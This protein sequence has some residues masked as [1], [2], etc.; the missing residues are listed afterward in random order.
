M[1]EAAVTDIPNALDRLAATRS[2]VRQILRPEYNDVQGSA[3][4]FPRS[5][6]MRALT[7]RG[8]ISALALVGVAILA[9]R[10][11]IAGRLAR[12]VPLV[13]LLRQLRLG[14]R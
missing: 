6:T 12:S 11:G 1:T 13:E 5:A 9:T 4:R 14:S 2:E 10:P 3:G 8:A 7:G